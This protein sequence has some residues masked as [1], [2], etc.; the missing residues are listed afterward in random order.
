MNT[1]KIHGTKKNIWNKEEYRCPTKGEF[2]P[3]LSE[4]LHAEGEHPAMLIVP[5]GAYIMVASGEGEIVAKRFYEEGFDTYVLSYT[6]ALFEGKPI[7]LQ[8]MKDIAKAA[9][10]IRKRNK[11]KL[12]ICGF[13]A[14]GHLTASLGVHWEDPRITPA[15]VSDVRMLRPDAEILCYPVI[16]SGEYAHRD[17]FV[18]LY[19]LDPTEEQLHYASV[20]EHVTANTPPTFLWH[21]ATD[22]DV[23]AEN[24]LRYAEAL[25]REKVLF[26][27]HLFS[28]G[29]HGYSL[30]DD[31]WAGGK[32]GGFYTM[33]QF[34][35][36]MQYH[37]D[38]QIPM[39]NGQSLP[40]KGSDFRAIFE[41]M[42][43]DYL[44]AEANPA[45]AMWPT[46]VMNWLK[47]EESL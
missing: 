44:K 40:P 9:C 42:P 30:A 22:T 14:G 4:Y 10:L 33:E 38:E 31:V 2:V 18:S 13:S 1:C 5:G 45:V 47:R 41:E 43:K 25:K 11:G 19:G 3:F 17:S 35:A 28:K 37:I 7:G 39:T 27:L 12:V 34:F 24:S 36:N 29:P 23:P 6:C 15:E 8:P 20:E 26:E 21:T 16:T 46:L 32:Y